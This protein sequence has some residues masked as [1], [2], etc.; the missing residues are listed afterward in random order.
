MLFVIKQQYR[1][2]SLSLNIGGEEEEEEEDREEDEIEQ[3]KEE[4]RKKKKKQEERLRGRG[5]EEK[6]EEEEEGLRGREEEE[7][8]EEEKGCWASFLYSPRR[9]LYLHS[10]FLVWQSKRILH[11][12]SSGSQSPQDQFS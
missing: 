11:I 9:H 3:D 7:E 1:I 5:E 4:E 10:S 12:L 8:V 2:F 6:G